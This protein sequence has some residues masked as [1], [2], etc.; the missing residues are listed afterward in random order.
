MVDRK[1][2]ETPTKIIE[3][4]AV[5]SHWYLAIYINIFWCFMWLYY[6]VKLEL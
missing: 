6:R 1:D 5:L 2:I 4:L 3:Y